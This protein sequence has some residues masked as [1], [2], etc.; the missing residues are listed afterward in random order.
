PSDPRTVEPERW[1]RQGL[2]VFYGV[3]I[4]AGDELLGVL[5]LG[6]PAGQEPTDDER[7]VIQL[8]ASHAAVA[9]RNARVLAQR[10]ARRR[11][12]EALLDLSRAMSRALEPSVVAQRVTESV[13]TLLGVQSSSLFRLDPDSGALVSLNVAGAEDVLGG[14]I[15]FPPG[16]GLV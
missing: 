14:Q 6:F 11:A 8:L 9:I 2:S 15:V 1:V 7:E 10:V 4:E 16:M 5:N 13:R 3:P 12:A